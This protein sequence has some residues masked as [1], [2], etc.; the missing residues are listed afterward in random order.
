MPID[1][2]H[3]RMKL[4]ANL[5]GFRLWAMRNIDLVTVKKPESLVDKIKEIIE[6]ANKRY[7][8]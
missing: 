7:N 1:N 8:A 3:F 2:H 4:K 5:L 6:E